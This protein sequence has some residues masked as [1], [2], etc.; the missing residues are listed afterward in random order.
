MI[1]NIVC[2]HLKQGLCVQHVNL[3]IRNQDIVRGIPKRYQSVSILYF[4]R[5]N[6]FPP[7]CPFA[8]FSNI[9]IVSIK[10]KLANVKLM[11]TES[12][13]IPI[14]CEKHNSTQQGL[15]KAQNCLFVHVISFF[16]FSAV[17][18]HKNDVI[19][20]AHKTVQ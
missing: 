4:H 12:S 14:G 9:P 3:C 8:K 16:Q 7:N 20:L 17:N 6:I 18:N 2:S 5:Y 1:L 15:L 13:L 10:T 19:N 11:N